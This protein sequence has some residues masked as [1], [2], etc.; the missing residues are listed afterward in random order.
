MC[1]G[2]RGVSG[3][4]GAELTND[5]FRVNVPVLEHAASGNGANVTREVFSPGAQV[6]RPSV[7]R[8]AQLCG[9]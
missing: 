3:D 7:V 9:R 2:D 4:V 1:R 5:L 6:F 8:P